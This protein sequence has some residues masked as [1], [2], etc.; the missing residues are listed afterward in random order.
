MRANCKR[1]VTIDDGCVPVTAL[2]IGMMDNNCFIVA[3]GREQGA[4]A[5]VV[6]P[7]GDAEAIQKALGWFKLE[8]IVCTHD[9]NDHLVALPELRQEPPAQRLF[10]AT[11]I[12]A[13]SKRAS[14]ATSA[15]G[16]LSAP[17]HVDRK[18]NDGDTIKLGSARVQ[19]HAYPG[20]HEGRHLPLPSWL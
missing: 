16:M 12:A 7:A 3:D 9:H 2:V 13:S 10:P 17:V 1:Q 6:D 4:P 20:P 19:G 15:T 11:P 8:T 5:M 18:V 14:R